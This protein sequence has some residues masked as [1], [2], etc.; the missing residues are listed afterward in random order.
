MSPSLH[1]LETLPHLP[2]DTP[3]EI[4]GGAGHLLPLEAPQ[5][6]AALLQ[7]FAESLRA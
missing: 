4:I 2:P 3:L 1:G 7:E 5:E 6:V